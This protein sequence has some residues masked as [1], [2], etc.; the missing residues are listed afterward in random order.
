M[1]A[2]GHVLNIQ[3]FLFLLNLEIKRARRYQNC[4]SLLSHTFGHLDPSVGEKASISLKTIAS[5][6]KSELRDTDIVG[7]GGGNRLLFMLPHA[8]MARAHNVRQRLEKILHYYGFGKNSF[9]IEIDEVCFPTHATNVDELLRRA[10]ISAL[11]RSETIHERT[12]QVSRQSEER[13]RSLVQNIPDIILVVARDGKILEVNRSV[14]GATVE[15]TIG[16]SVYDNVAPEHRNTVRKLLERVFQTGKPDTYEILGVGQ[17]GLNTAWYETRIVP[18]ERNRQVVA[19]TLIS[20]DITERKRMEERL[21]EHGERFRR[22]IE[23]ARNIVYRFRLVP[24]KGFEYLSPA[25]A[26]ITGYTLEEL[27]ADYNLGFKLVHPDDR[28]L[29]EAMAKGDTTKRKP[30]IIRWVRKDGKITWT[31]HQNIPI[32]DE[33]GTLVSVEGV[34]RDITEG[35]GKEPDEEIGR[36]MAD[37]ARSKTELEQLALITS[38]ELDEPVRM[39]ARYVYLL[40]RRYKGKLDSDADKFIDHVL[41]GT[42]R[43]QRLINDLLAYSR[44]DSE[45]KDFAPANCEKVFDRTIVNLKKVIEE[46]DAAVS[47]DPLPT[48][49]ADESQLIQLFQH[50]IGNAIKFRE[51]EPPGVHVSVEKRENEW[52][53]SVQDNGIGID[54]EHFERIFMIFQRL[55]SEAK[56]RGAGIG[57]SISRKIVERHGG[58]IWVNSEPGKGSTFYFTIPIA[59]GIGSE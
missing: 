47:H 25:A 40:A 53:F 59:D 18:N 11:E 22:L 23:D 28:H 4:M 30:F 15:E 56:Y 41:Y 24:A 29:L 49:M 13:W 51:D 27:Y 32:C 52:L 42:N 16:K 8:D 43:M 58:R 35:K 6:L 36:A 14:S 1:F 9:T 46:S 19:V 44:V 5:L 2:F 55:N 17:H 50:L 39:V 31:E 54:P 26:D 34:A 21:R 3:S 12:E 20:T 37:L 33:A 7:Q 45:G 10:G 57:L 38:R 48:V